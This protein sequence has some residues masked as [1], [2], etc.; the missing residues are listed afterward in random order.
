MK[1]REVYQSSSGAILVDAFKFVSRYQLRSREMSYVATATSTNSDLSKSSSGSSR[2]FPVAYFLSHFHSDHYTGLSESWCNGLI[3]C[4]VATASLLTDELRVPENY[5]VPLALNNTYIFSLQS[6]TCTAEVPELLSSSRV[7]A[8]LRSSPFDYYAV[9]LIPA[10]H[11]PGSVMLVFHAPQLFGLVLHTGDFRFN[12]SALCWR[13]AIANDATPQWMPASCQATEECGNLT[14]PQAPFYEEFIGD[15]AAL[16][17][18]L[19]S[20]AVDILFLDNT[21]CSPAFQF[22]T[23]WQSTQ[24]VVEVLR[25][26]FLSAA[27]A[28]ASPDPQQ[29][30]SAASKGNRPSRVV[31][32][33]VLIGA[34][35]I[36]KERVALAVQEAFQRRN[37]ATPAS[38]PLSTK[39]PIFVA[40][41]RYRLLARL[42][43]HTHCFEN[44][45]NTSNGAKPSGKTPATPLEEDMSLESSGAAMATAMGNVSVAAYPV[46]LPQRSQPPHSI[47]ISSTPT[48]HTQRCLADEFDRLEMEDATQFNLSICM[49]P[50]SAVGYRSL[51][52]LAKGE[53]DGWV[54]TGDSLRLDLRSYDRILAVEPTGWTKKTVCR[55]Y[56][57][58]VIHLRV[59]YSEH[60]SYDE[61]L[62]FVQYIN[63]RRVVPTVSEE[64]YRMSESLFVER[65]PRLGSRLS[66]T[67]PL[68]RFFSAAPIRKQVNIDPAGHQR[69]SKDIDGIATLSTLPSAVASESQISCSSTDLI[70]LGSSQ[71]N[72]RVDK[73]MVMHFASTKS[74]LDDRPQGDAKRQRVNGGM[75][76]D[77][78]V[79]NECQIVGMKHAV[80]EISDDEVDDTNGLTY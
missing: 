39:V 15:N 18:V 50:M 70:T 65:A 49:V 53:S 14:P 55:S 54:D 63:P 56:S 51:D 19:Q 74:S 20:T 35:T 67:Q 33:A 7:Q 23:Q 44:M 25:S 45:A 48:S 77:V 76:K 41:A 36:G 59:P 17:D 75:W 28:Q 58:S 73:N 42:Q 57:K 46:D 9:R 43:Y 6:A 2:S 1:P 27:A 31:Q 30:S 62:R 32:I 29:S 21:F 40:P 11:C 34:Y 16:Q 8:I 47:E 69:L 26:S 24:T 38:T 13:D 5:V 52:A 4:S 79:D 60:S 3:Y 68:S 72:N 10:N 71:N 61:L 12:G 22:P 64:Q 78:S 66:N 80:V 37:T